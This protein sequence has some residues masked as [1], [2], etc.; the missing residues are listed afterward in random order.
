VPVI[1]PG[2]ELPM[3]WPTGPDDHRGDPSPPEPVD[4]RDEGPIGIRAVDV[5]DEML[6]LDEER[7][8]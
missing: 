3:P 4:E 7:A 2:H 8:P 5:E 6:G 1:D